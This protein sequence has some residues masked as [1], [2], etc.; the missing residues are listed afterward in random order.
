MAKISSSGGSFN[1]QVAS[2]N[3]ANIVRCYGSFILQ[4]LDSK[5]YLT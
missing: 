3:I 5:D 1:D 4:S 2:N